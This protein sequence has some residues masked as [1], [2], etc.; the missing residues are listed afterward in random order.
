MSIL[1]EVLKYI[2]NKFSIVLRYRGLIDAVIIIIV[3]ASISHNITTFNVLSKTMSDHIDGTE[4]RISVLENDIILIGTTINE[5]QDTDTK[6]NDYNMDIYLVGER[7]IPEEH[8]RLGVRIMLDNGIDPGVLFAIIDSRSEGDLFKTIP[9]STARG[10]GLMIENTAAWVYED[11]MGKKGYT[12]AMQTD[13]VRSVEIVAEY[14]VHLMKVH[15]GNIE[16][17]SYSYVGSRDEEF[18]NKVKSYIYQYNKDLAEIE[19]D[20]IKGG[21]KS[22]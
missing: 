3:I 18:Y 9:R 22:D 1:K 2:K 21:N 19:Y 15:D 10:Y 4:N 5:L 14:I 7:A 6:S 8:A 16:E 20:Y 13:G 17:V 12:H 11:I